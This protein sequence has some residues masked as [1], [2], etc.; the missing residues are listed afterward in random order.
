MNISDW[1]VT[2][3]PLSWS[4]VPTRRVGIIL[5]VRRGEPDSEEAVRLAK[6]LG[7]EVRIVYADD[8]RVAPFLVQSVGTAVTPALVTERTV[9]PGLELVRGFL[10]HAS[11]C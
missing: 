9:L 11:R 1:K 4:H 2:P 7:V 8:P 6:S 10:M 3:S 5:L